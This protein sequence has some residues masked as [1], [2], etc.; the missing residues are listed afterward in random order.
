MDFLQILK[1]LPLKPIDFVLEIIKIW[2]K[3]L[4]F[5][6]ADFFL[7]I[8][9]SICWYRFSYEFLVVSKICFIT[10]LFEVLNKFKF[11][12]LY[13][14][15]DYLWKQI[16]IKGWCLVRPRNPQ[17]RPCGFKNLYS[18]KKSAT[19]TR[20]LTKSIGFHQELSL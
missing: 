4:D 18:S 2:Q 20:Q 1:S 17:P 16:C 10:I 9:K 12:K 19:V 3:S 14:V 13:F 8:F 6:F 15:K 5:W 7:E 11:E